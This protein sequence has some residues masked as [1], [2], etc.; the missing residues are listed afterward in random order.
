MS[1]IKIT[2]DST[3][4][5]PP[6]LCKKFDISIAPLSVGMGDRSCHDGVDVTAEELFRFVEQTGTLPTTAAVSPGE[7]VEFFRPF[8]EAGMEVI[9]INI[10]T[11]LSSCHQN[12]ALAAE[13]L[14]HIHPIDSYNLSS[15]SGHLALAAA[16]MAAAGMEASAIVE[17]L[18]EMKTR[19]D[20]SFIIQT[21]D[22][23]HKGGRCSGLAAFGANL[24]KIRPEIEVADGAMQVGRKYRGSMEKTVLDYVSGRLEG[25]TDL[26]LHRIFV[27]HST[28]PRE[29]VDA[30]IARVKELQPFEEVIESDAGCTISTHCGPACIGVLFFTK[31]A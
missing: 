23:L 19:L 20:V 12:A 29:V 17:S 24:L 21:L 14:G 2:C 7:Y 6:A 4:D 1:A 26:E 22:F 8:V 11:K 30:A 3:C 27:T 10:S 25:R 16:E 13:E 5:L 9:H 18:N 15:G 31:K 28:M